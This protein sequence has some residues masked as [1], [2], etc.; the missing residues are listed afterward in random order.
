MAKTKNQNNTTPA[1]GTLMKEKSTRDKILHA[2][3]KVFSMHPYHSA[4]IRMI[5]KEGGF[6]HAIIRYYYPTKA[7]LFCA[8]AV[9]ICDEIYQKND[10]WL[11]EIT[12]LDPKQAISVY[13]DRFLH[14]AFEKPEALRIIIQN[15]AQPDL[16]NQVPGYD[17]LTDF[18]TRIR[19]RFETYLPVRVSHDLIVRYL[20]SFN[21]L[22]LFYLGASSYESALL[23]M[24]PE[25]REYGEWVK[26]TMVELFYPMLMEMVKTGVPKK[27][28]KGKS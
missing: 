8:V 28:E 21:G 25:S 26:R 12:G 17:I 24:S 14:Y 11:K 4:S 13:M 19:T 10:K 7:D 2:A 9:N 3:T 6:G 18:L 5:G 22:L 23:G 20:D 15:A 16:P 1:S 27:P